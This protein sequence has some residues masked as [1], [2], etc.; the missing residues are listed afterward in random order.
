MLIR[1][2]SYSVSSD[3]LRT[4]LHKDVDSPSEFTG[5]DI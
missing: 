5:I 2:H 3:R 1:N 4:A